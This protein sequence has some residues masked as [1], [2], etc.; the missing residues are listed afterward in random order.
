MSIV[1]QSGGLNLLE[2]SQPAKNFLDLHLLHIY[3]INSHYCLF[4]VDTLKMSKHVELPLFCILLYIIMVQFVEYILSEK[5]KIYVM[6][7]FLYFGFKTHFNVF[8]SFMLNYHF[9]FFSSKFL[10][11]ILNAFV[12]L[13]LYHARSVQ[14][15][16]FIC[17]IA[18]TINLLTLFFAPHFPC[19][20]FFRSKLIILTL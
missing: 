8:L 6:R 5:H 4:I 15:I 18:H 20:F 7:I 17:F 14:R 13:T 11:R 10:T 12:I 2:P 16:S 19:S 3:V 9:L 1:L